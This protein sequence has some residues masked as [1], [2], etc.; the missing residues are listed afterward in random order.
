MVA[1]TPVRYRYRPALPRRSP[2][3][4]PQGAAQAVP[5]A[6][7]SHPSLFAILIVAAMPT[8]PFS[9]RS[10][11]TLALSLVAS[12]LFSILGDPLL[13]GQ[14]PAKVVPEKKD[15][16]GGFALVELIDEHLNKVCST[17]EDIKTVERTASIEGTSSYGP[18]SGTCRLVVD[19]VHERGFQSI[20]IAGYTRTLGWENDHRWSIDS[21]NGEAD[22]PV[23][24]TLLVQL[25]S[26]PTI[27]GQFKHAG[28]KE[29]KGAFFLRRV[30]HFNQASSETDIGIEI[31][32]GVEHWGGSQ[33]EIDAKT[34][35]L[36]K[37]QIFAPSNNNQPT[38]A[39][40]EFSDFKKT[41]GFVIAHHAEVTI[42]HQGLTMRLR[43]VQTEWNPSIDESI[44]NK[45]KSQ[46]RKNEPKPA[47]SSP[48]ES[49]APM[50]APISSATVLSFIHGFD[51]D[52]DLRISRSEADED[53]ILVFDQYDLDQDQFLDKSETQLILAFVV[54]NRDFAD[55]EEAATLARKLI[56]KLDQNNNGRIDFSE[57][58]EPIQ[59]QFR[60]VDLDGNGSLDLNE[61]R[62]AAAVI[63]NKSR[64]SP[65]GT[66]DSPSGK[67]SAAQ[68]IKYMDHDQNGTIGLSEA[69]AELKP[70]FACIDKNQDG[71][72]DLNE[73]EVLAEYA[74]RE[75]VNQHP[76]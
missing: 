62:E 27:L 59:A 38:F 58:T 25:L 17:D 31:L 23:H 65:P 53:L 28:G 56:K 55:T 29:D 49:I 7:A 66:N 73:A 24:E 1:S 6:V 47:L 48:S 37:A 33:F 5:T 42:P 46:N 51:G 21:I 75:G 15:A 10:T 64:Q 40:L 8:A 50:T 35:Y 54:K 2:L 36:T 34:K 45:N 67:I 13:K 19:L 22:L 20:E 57:A 43:F 4:L 68:I 11:C 39:K 44:F 16:E 26:L 30:S 76:K 52:G 71:E 61:A 60:V 72:I 70:N 12:L 9:C 69:N 18:F 14:S 41:G 32:P 63:K 74:N 3:Q